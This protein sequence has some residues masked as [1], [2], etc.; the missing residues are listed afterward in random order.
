LADLIG[1]FQV[2]ATGPFLTLAQVEQLVLD[3]LEPLAS[4]PLTS[5][6][7]AP[8]YYIRASDAARFLRAALRTWITEV[9]PFLGQAQGIGPCCPPPDKCVLLAEITLTLNPGWTATAVAIDDSRRPFLVP[10]SLLQ[11]LA[12]QESPAA[13]A[14]SSYQTV[15]AGYFQMNGSPISPTFNGL[16]ATPADGVIALTFQGYNQANNYIVKGTVTDSGTT[17][18]PIFEFVPPAAPEGLLVRIFDASGKALASTV[19]F[20]VE[21]SQIGGGL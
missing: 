8:P 3:L 12:Y 13:L 11:E 4:P 9:R 2:S 21:I 5:P 19:G 17:A 16:T 7:S 15:A 6:P 20:M 1:Q 18:A 10:T 14:S